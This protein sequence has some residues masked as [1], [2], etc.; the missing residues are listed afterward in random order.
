[1]QKDDRQGN[2]QAPV[3]GND[4]DMAGAGATPAGADLEPGQGEPTW[5]QPWVRWVAC[6]AVL[7][8]LSGLIGLSATWVIAERGN[9]RVLERIALDARRPPP[10]AVTKKNETGPDLARQHAAPAAA[11]LD[12]PVD[13]SGQPNRLPQQSVQTRPADNDAVATNA[14]ATAPAKLQSGAAA[15]RA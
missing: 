3:P 7:F 11:T 10:E 8:G 15:R 2:P 1:M 14:C 5:Q 6:L 9:N 4:A 12:F 13:G